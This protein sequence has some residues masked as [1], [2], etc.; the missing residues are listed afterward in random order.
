MIIAGLQKFSLI[1]YPGKTCAILF[2]RGCNFR[3]HYCHNPEL[4]IPQ[5]YAQEIPLDYLFDF[6]ISRQGKLDAV[7]ITGG[8]PT[9]HFDLLEFLAEIK[10]LGFL[11]KLDSNGSRPEVLQRIIQSRLVDYLAMDVK[12]PLEQ[13][14]KTIVTPVSAEKLQQSIQLIMNSGVEYEFRTTIVKSLLSLDDL[15]SIAQTLKGAQRYFLQRF[16]PGTVINATFNNEESYTKIELAELAQELG[17]YVTF[18]GVR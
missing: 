11:V 13:Y 1:D 8:E 10:K 3:C 18:C 2:T 7:E 9:M 6:L 17:Q 5:Q 12:A 15:R 14:R 4:V 16:R